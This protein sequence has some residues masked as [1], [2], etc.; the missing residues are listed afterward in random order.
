[1]KIGKSADQAELA[2]AALRNATE[3]G[4]TKSGEAAPAK[5]GGAGDESTKVA[6][7][8]AASLLS[9]SGGAAV[10]DTEKVARVQEAIANGTYVINPE[11]IASRLI[12]NAKEVLANARGDE[13]QGSVQGQTP[14]AS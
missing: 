4:K 8:S 10:F 14:S 1:M 2:A 11:A 3:S 12:A 7:S 6:L 13:A 9:T 5:A